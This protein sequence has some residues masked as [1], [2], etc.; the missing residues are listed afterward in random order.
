VKPSPRLSPLIGIATLSVLAT[1]A[2]AVVLAQYNFTHTGTSTANPASSDPQPNSVAGTFTAAG[3][4]AP[5]NGGVSGS[6][7]MAFLRTN[8]LT[9]S[10]ATAVTAGDYFTFTFTPD[11]GATFNLTSITFDFGGSNSGT[12]GA[13]AFTVTAALRSD[14]EAVD[15][16]TDLAAPFSKTITANTTNNQLSA[17]PEV[18]LTAPEFQNV[19]GPI[20]FRFFISSDDISTSLKIARMDNVILN[21][22]VLTIPEPASSALIVAGV[23]VLGLRRRRN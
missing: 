20:T 13:P 3:A 11:V 12:T 22:T 2:Q 6:S 21:G 16:S 9:T 18:L 5:A 1:S 7:D 8:Q 15:Y 19:S 10:T 17:A 14:A 23:A 4:D